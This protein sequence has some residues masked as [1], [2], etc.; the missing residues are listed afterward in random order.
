MQ[1]TGSV[2]RRGSNDA[3][4]DGKV[5]EL[6]KDYELSSG[7]RLGLHCNSSAFV[8]RK[9]LYA[10]HGNAFSLPQEFPK[11]WIAV[12]GGNPSAFRC[13]SAR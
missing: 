12:Y 3:C 2:A 10:S 8:M 6:M 13:W 4:G 1:T 9:L 5:R 11:S 7:V